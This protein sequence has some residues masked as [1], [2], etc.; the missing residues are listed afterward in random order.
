MAADVDLVASA[1]VAHLE[2]VTARRAA[3]A[4]AK[5]P[6]QDR[7]RSFQGGATIWGVFDIRG[8]C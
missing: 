2:G 7:L 1:L 3:D 5:A 6:P 4:V 8:A